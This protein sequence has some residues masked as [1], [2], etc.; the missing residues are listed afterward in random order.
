MLAISKKLKQENRYTYADYVQWNDPNRWEIIDGVPYM[1]P[2][3][4]TIHQSISMNLIGEIGNF[5]KGKSCKIFSA[6][7]DVRLAYGG[8]DDIVVQPDIMI[9]CDKNNLN[10][11]GGIGAPDIV[12]EIVLPSSE[13]MDKTIK[14]KLYKRVGVAEYWIVEP[15][16]KSVQVHKFREGKPIKVYTNNDIIPLDILQGF[17]I[18]LADIFAI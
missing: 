16:I 9:F 6:P 8:N 11:D 12:M 14:F 18:N 17:N 2:R 5:L 10:E 7:L 3:P 1:M 4:D 13:K 15:D